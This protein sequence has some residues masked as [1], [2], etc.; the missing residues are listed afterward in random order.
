MKQF[1]SIKKAGFVVL[2]TALVLASAC[3]SDEKSSGDEA[4][5][6]EGTITISGAFALYPLANVWAEEFRK[7]YPD[8]KFNISG[9]GAGK[10]MADLLGGA[11]DLAM[12]S[13]DISDIEKS[14]GA[15]GF[16]V[17]KDAV[18]PTI[19]SQN[20]ILNQ[21]K[22]EGMT[23]DELTKLFLGNGAKVW[24]KSSTKVNVYTRSDAS[25][26]A[27]VWAKYLGGSAQEEL[28]GIAV[29]G[30]PGVAD[31]VR[32]DKN[33]IGYNNVIFVY[34]VKTGQKY[35]G[36]DVAPIDINGNGTIDQDEN[37]YNSLKDITTAIANG[38]YPSPPAR[39]LFLVTKGKPKN[40]AV[41]VFLN[42]VLTEGQKH[43]VPNGYILLEKQK[44]IDQINRL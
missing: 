21:I 6:V 29:F 3:G 44:I 24:K 4:E 40:Y 30:D 32:K 23:K 2:T 10:G 25:G 7:Q 1:F 19:N 28:K 39:D 41:K 31:A 13:K 34:D 36:M 16:S 37:F 5:K 38:K 27:E 14:Q 15:Y 20:P 12:Y 9:G 33:S 35:P 42:W 18:I 17:T 26:A 43:V 8:V 22:S 11:A